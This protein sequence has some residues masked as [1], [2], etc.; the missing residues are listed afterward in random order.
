VLITSAEQPLRATA[1]EPVNE[2]APGSS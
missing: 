1:I 2:P